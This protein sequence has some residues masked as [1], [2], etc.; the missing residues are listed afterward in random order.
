MAIVSSSL[1]VFAQ[2]EIDL[3][4]KVFYRNEWSLA[5]LLNSNGFGGNYRYGKRIDA[6]NKRLWEVDFSYMKDPKER[7][8]TSYSS[9]GA[10]FV[11]GKKNLAFDFRFALGRQHE[12]YRK[13]DVG[14]IA[15]RYFYNYGPAV[16]ILKPMYYKIGKVQTVPPLSGQGPAYQIIVQQDDPE[17][18]DPEWV[19]SNT[20]I[21][22]RASFFKGF[23]QPKFI[24]G[25]FG[26]FG[27]NFEFSKQD[28]IVHALECGLTGEVFAKKVEIMDFSMP[29]MGQTELAKN[30]Q[31]FLTIFLS[32]RFG[33]IVDP[34]E[35]K[36][37]RKRSSEISY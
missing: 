15:I 9:S 19:F 37:S 24:P 14:G 29:N 26:K 11:Y 27:F 18:F 35:V 6:R 12:M 32:Y 2:G 10:R 33:R 7:K 4:P 28:R 22:S 1:T 34:Y 25:V 36:K 13:H 16:V 17:K 5:F 31:F 20:E 23:D 30:Q 21:I 3:Q 8:S